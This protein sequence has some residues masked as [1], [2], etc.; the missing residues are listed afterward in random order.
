[1]FFYEQRPG[2]V[3]EGCLRV[4]GFR[5]ASVSLLGRREQLEVRM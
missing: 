4:E 1:M 5:D 2:D 3:D